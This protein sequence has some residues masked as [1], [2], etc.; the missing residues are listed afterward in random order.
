MPSGEMR[1]WNRSVRDRS[2]PPG[3]TAVIAADRGAAVSA[4]HPHRIVVVGGGAAGLELVTQLGNKV[5][6]R[7]LADITLIEK[8]RTHLWKP[9]LH[10]VAAGSMDPSEHELNYLAQA[11]WHN[12]RFRFGEM[13]GLDRRE[14]QVHL[15]ATKDEEGREIT[16]PRSFPYDTLVVAIGSVTN[17]FGTPGVAEYAIPLETAEQA[18]RFN[19]RLVNACIRAHAQSEP[20]RHGQLHVA[21]IG[22]GATGTEL[23]A[24]LYQ[25][26]REVVAYGLDRVDPERDIRIVLIEAADRILPALPPRISDATLKL[27][28][29][30]GVEVRTGARVSH[31]TADGVHLV[32]GQFIPSEL[33]VWSAGITAPDVLRQLDGLETNRLNQLVVTPSLQT[34]RDPDVFAIGDCAACPR[35][36]HPDPVPPRAQAAHQQSSHLARQLPRRLAGKAPQP[37]SYRDFGSLVSLGN[38]T[39][40]G[41]LMGALVGKSFFIEGHFARLMYRSLYKMH[42]MALHGPAK[43][44]FGSLGRRLSRRAQPP[45]KLH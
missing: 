16:P 11:H 26:A 42:E 5:G 36:G 22:A 28:Q 17:D 30:L 31:V 29:V 2:A 32:D 13:I 38:Y 33:V 9:L 10:S 8:K 24:E 7:G 15:A 21:I 19:R 44:L 20:V 4:G 23:A 40:V 1:P 6:K 35:P 27:L 37:F 18:V 39:T 41:N 14:R 34:T 45:V 3:P 12:F 43:A 25:T